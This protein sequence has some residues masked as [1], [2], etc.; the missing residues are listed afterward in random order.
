MQRSPEYILSSAIV[1]KDGK[2]QIDMTMD[3][4]LESG[5]SEKEY[6]AYQQKID[7]LNNT[8]GGY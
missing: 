2:F 4:I 1:F 7:I 6:E 8:I 5:I 3:E